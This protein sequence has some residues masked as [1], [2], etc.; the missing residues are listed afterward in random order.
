MTA[1]PPTTWTD[2]PDPWCAKCGAPRADHEEAGECPTCDECWHSSPY[3]G[4]SEPDNPAVT[5]WSEFVCRACVAGD[6]VREEV[7]A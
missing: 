5:C 1:Y 7:T 6:V 2:G 4:D 3:H